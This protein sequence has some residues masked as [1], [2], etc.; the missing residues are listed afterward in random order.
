MTASRFPDA[1]AAIQTLRVDQRGFPVPAFVPW[2]DG[3]P[4]F[5]AI[6][7][8]TVERV[9]RERLCWICGL[10]NS[11]GSA[12]VIG[13]MCGVNRVAPEPPSH[14]LCARFAVRACPFLSQPMAKRNSRNLPEHQPPPGVMIPRNP[15]VTAI[16]ITS[17]YRAERQ[18]E[19]G[20]LF[21]IGAPIRVEWWC[22]GRAATRQEVIRSVQTG[23][24]ALQEIAEQDGPEA[25]AAL[26]DQVV[27]FGRL[28]PDA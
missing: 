15:G 28:V 2:I 19:G 11:G 10:R 18:P 23:L 7:P 27:R 9:H 16:W 20:L 24:P 1:P 21:R 25:V 5:R 8:G 14:L 17:T 12:F 4:E 6:E 26:R 13:P 22:E 3:E